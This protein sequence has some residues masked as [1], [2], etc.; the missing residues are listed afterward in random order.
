LYNKK[1][2][3]IYNN[4]KLR[5]S[6]IHIGNADSGHYYSLIKSNDGNE[7]WYEFNDELVKEFDS[8]DIPLVAFGGEDESA[9]RNLGQ[10]SLNA[11]T[12]KSIGTKISNAYMLFYER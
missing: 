2:P 8:Q 1:L 7:N 9:A 11:A 10:Y 3:K 5:G 4:Y 12:I 6:L